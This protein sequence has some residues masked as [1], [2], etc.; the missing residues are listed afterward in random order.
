MPTLGSN[1]TLMIFWG[2]AEWKWSNANNN[3][4]KTQQRAGE[5]VV[6]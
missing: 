5:Y 2:G 6:E 1:F 4:R 3:A